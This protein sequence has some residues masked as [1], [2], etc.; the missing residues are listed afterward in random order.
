LT[1]IKKVTWVFS[2]KRER[3]EF[4]GEIRNREEKRD[5]K[6]YWEEDKVYDN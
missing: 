2:G 6:A 1:C 4:E 3:N 5:W